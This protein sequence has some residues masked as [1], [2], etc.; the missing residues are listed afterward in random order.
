LT[1]VFNGS[2]SYHPFDQ[3]V[4]TLTASRSVSPSYF[5]SEITEAAGFTGAIQQRLFGK[6][7]VNVSGGFTATSYKSTALGLTASRE[8][9]H[10]SI[11]VRFSYPFFN[12]GT[13]S[14]FYDWSDNS[15]NTDGF[16]YQSNQ[17]G[18]ELGYRF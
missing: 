3:T 2:I 6:L 14:V 4:L 8:D 16:K 17:A 15:S 13:V 11:N 18:L 9:E 10:S 1:P 12:R 5:Q 7:T